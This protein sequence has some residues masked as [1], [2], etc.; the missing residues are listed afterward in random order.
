MGQPFRAVIDLCP[1]SRVSAA[2]R[3][4]LLLHTIWKTSRNRIDLIL[5]DFKPGGASVPILVP[6]KMTSDALLRNPT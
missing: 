5:A 1:N 6:A 4:A 3:I 2:L